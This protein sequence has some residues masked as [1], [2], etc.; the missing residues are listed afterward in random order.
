MVASED[1]GATAEQVCS[2]RS[3][4]ASVCVRR[5]DEQH[6]FLSL[7]NAAR[8]VSR[9]RRTLQR[10]MVEG[11]STETMNGAKYVEREELLSWYRKKIL[12]NPTRPSRPIGTMA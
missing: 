12:A 4:G 1:F 11:M 8:R 3:Q 6:E 5:Q 2:G 9:D 7:R 10:W